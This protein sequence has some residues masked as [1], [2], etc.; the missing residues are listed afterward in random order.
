MKL[1]VSPAACVLWSLLF[2]WQMNMMYLV[3]SL[4]IK[5]LNHETVHTH[6][7]LQGERERARERDWKCGWNI[8]ISLGG[9]DH[10]QWLSHS[11][12]DLRLT[13][14]WKQARQLHGACSQP[15]AC[16]TVEVRKRER[17]KEEKRGNKEQKELQESFC[18][19]LFVM[20]YTKIH[21]HAR[22]VLSDK[23]MCVNLLM[24]LTF[25]QQSTVLFHRNPSHTASLFCKEL[26]GC[27]QWESSFRLMHSETSLFSPLCL[28]AG[29]ISIWVINY[30]Q[31][32]KF[33]QLNEKMCNKNS[34]FVH[35]RVAKAVLQ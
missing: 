4:S 17:L 29:L 26:N 23:W 3:L 2:F 33:K 31:A 6:H 24:P 10:W 13:L 25:W 27:R 20:K 7:L 12:G 9:G 5:T 21:T 30:F 11:M 8:K 16:L 22:A 35:K 19:I 28:K 32:P 1:Q 14:P 18:C 15:M 34:W